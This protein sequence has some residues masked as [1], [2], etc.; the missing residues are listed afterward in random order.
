MSKKKDLLLKIRYH[1]DLYSNQDTEE[2]DD[3]TY[4]GL[5]SKYISLGG[6]FDDIAEVK[7]SNS[8]EKVR[9]P[10]DV[11]SLDKIHTEE[12]VR[13]ALIR[14]CPGEI[15]PKI[16]GLTLLVYGKDSSLEPG[17]EDE[18][19]STKG[20]YG[21]GEKVNHNATKIENCIAVDGIV[22]RAEV[23]MP[24]SKFKEINLRRVSEGLKPFKNARNAAAGMVR[25]LDESKVEGLSYMAYNIMG[26]TATEKYQLFMLQGQGVDIVDSFSYDEKDIEDAVKFIMTYNELKREDLDY[27]I[28]GLV[29]KSNA[30]NSINTF[31]KTGHHYKNAVAFKFPSI[32]QWT[33]LLR[34]VQ[35]VGRTGQI[36][37]VAEFE[38]LDILGGTVRRATLFNHG[39]MTKLGVTT[40]CMIEVIKANDVIPKVVAVRDSIGEAF[41]QI[42]V[43]P[44]CGEPVTQK[45]A[46]IFCTNLD[47]DSN[48]MGK[49]NH[50]TKKEALAIT[51]LAIKTIEKLCDEGFIITPCDLFD[52]TVEDILTIDGFLLKSATKL[53]NK[54]QSCRVVPL[55]NFLY[56][57]GLPLV[58]RTASKDIAEKLGSLDAVMKDIV[59]DDC[60]EIITIGG[61]GEE[62]ISSLKAN[63]QLIVTLA[64]F[65]TPLDMPKQIK[66]EPVGELL[67]FVFTGDFTNGQKYYEELAKSKGHKVSGAV[68]GST[69]YLVNNDI[70]SPSSKNKKAKELGKPIISELDFLELLNER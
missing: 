37:P 31:G 30:E 20:S 14:F 27:E 60:K 21:E 52:V 44:T 25:A 33:K 35:Q 50:M 49:T 16:D 54:I 12:E 43:C 26:S 57:A 59:F 62:T 10:Y 6:S 56:A 18:V 29:I 11:K 3:L 22:Y 7:S 2:I 48:I 51:G 1:N 8:Y 38:P 42:T 53:Y 47:C 28:D 55:T 61:I 67:K 4:D 34:V 32:P 66:I 68:S 19:W 45:G 23:F 58:G 63:V 5:V 70:D 39:I 41:P 17:F 64:K 9:H 65:V 46:N 36:T 15:Q 40:D 24:K 13:A 69:N